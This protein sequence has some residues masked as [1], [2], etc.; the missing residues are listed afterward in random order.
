LSRK[1]L[2]GTRLG[3]GSSPARKVHLEKQ[4]LNCVP[5]WMQGMV[6]AVV[7]IRTQLGKHGETARAVARL[8]GVKLAF[9][10]MG[11]ADVVASVES[12]SIGRLNELVLRIAAT[13]GVVLTETLVSGEE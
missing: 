7:L 13:K 11:R 9:P 4:R 8:N 12:P 6:K 10:V 1:G 3:G 2:T 5:R